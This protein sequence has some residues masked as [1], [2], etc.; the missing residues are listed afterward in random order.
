MTAVTG[1]M[2]T[3]AARHRGRR[4]STNRIMLG[5]ATA[6][7][8]VSTVPLI[9]IVAYVATQGLQA[10]SV[11]FFTSEPTPVGIPGGGIANAIVGSFITVGLASLLA[12][13]VGLLIGLYAAAR[14]GSRSGS[15]IRF[16]TDTIAGVP[17]IVMG[18]FAYTIVVLPQGHFSALSGGVVLSF[19]M[20]PIIV[21][22]TEEMLR[23]VPIT[24]REG[25]L[26]LGAAEWRTAL[27]VVLPAA[28]SGIVTGLMLAIARAAGEAAPMLFTAF[29]NSFFSTDL[30]Q[31]IATLPH[32]IY[33]YALSPYED[34]KAKAWG[35]ALVLIV[36]V[37][38]LNVIARAVVGWRS[39]GLTGTRG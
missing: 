22:S 17:S 7:A 23:L 19:I 1:V 20:L 9:W 16:L 27:R 24:L 38:A 31:P 18:V 21:R 36:L 11:D 12:L 6:A 5:A 10:I 2:S 14:A 26:A 13:P 33:V 15:A 3:A 32:T 29:G 39:R 34:W 37:F 4:V 30:Q 28:T 25:S 8:V 35:T